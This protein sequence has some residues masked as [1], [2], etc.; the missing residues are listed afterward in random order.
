VQI[1]G[2]VA[3]QQAAAAARRVHV[4]AHDAGV[5]LREGDSGEEVGRRNRDDSRAELHD[6][7]GTAVRVG[8]GR[9]GP[10]QRAH[11]RLQGG[12]VGRAVHGR[13]SV[14]VHPVAAAVAGGR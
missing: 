10:L 5:A 4:A 12:S 14:V 3:G 6:R 8:A 11:G 1:G 9:R 13:R 2:R 7:A